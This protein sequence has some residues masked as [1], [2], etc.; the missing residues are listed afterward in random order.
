M[1]DEDMIG[2][3]SLPIKTT[4]EK[5]DRGVPAAKSSQVKI[6]SAEPCTRGNKSITLL[7]TYSK[8]LT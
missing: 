5:K 2:P 1:K 7:I 6:T 3:R 4:G 8:S